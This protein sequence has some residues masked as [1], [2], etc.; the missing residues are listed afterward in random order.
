MC[1]VCTSQGSGSPGHTEHSDGCGAFPVLPL[2]IL[3]IHPLNHWLVFWVCVQL[4]AQRVVAG[5][6]KHKYQHFSLSSD[7]LLPGAALIFNDS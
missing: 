7:E 6:L 2:E 1:H 3:L 5:I 4:P